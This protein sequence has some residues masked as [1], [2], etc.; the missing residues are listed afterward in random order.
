MTIV[1]VSCET[2][3]SLVQRKLDY[4]RPAPSGPGDLSNLLQIAAS[5]LHLIDRQIGDKIRPLVR[6]GLSAISAAGDLTCSPAFAAPLRHQWRAEGSD[7]A[8]RSRWQPPL[9]IVPTPQLVAG[10]NECPLDPT[11]CKVH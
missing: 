2:G 7:W 3:P 6:A 8:G 10:T 4:Q 1:A 5:V 9:R 11:D